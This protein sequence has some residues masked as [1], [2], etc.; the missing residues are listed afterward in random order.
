MLK[1]VT[2]LTLFLLG[3]LAKAQNTEIKN[4]TDFSKIN[5]NGN[6]ELIYVQNP[7]TLVSVMSTDAELTKNTVVEVSN[8]TLQLYTISPSKT[9]VKI[10]VNNPEVGEIKASNS[11]VV[12]LPEPVQLT[13]LKINLLVNAQFNGMINAAKK[14]RLV[15]DEYSSFNGRV[16]TTTLVGNAKGNARINISGQAQQTALNMGGNTLLLAGNFRSKT[17]HLSANGQAKINIFAPEKLN[18]HLSEEAQLNYRGLPANVQLN[19]EAI[20]TSVWHKQPIIGYNE[21]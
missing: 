17:I 8:H 19:E 7:K 1:I 13:Q 4:I 14:V 2:T 21:K 20:A 11:A 10:Y 3:M 18:V 12:M 6:I 15:A 16:E 5:V 9:A